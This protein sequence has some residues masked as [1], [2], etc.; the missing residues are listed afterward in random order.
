MVAGSWRGKVYGFFESIPTHGLAA[1]AQ[2]DGAVDVCANA[3]RFKGRVIGLTDDVAALPEQQ[4]GD[5]SGGQGR[6]IGAGDGRAAAN[7]ALMR[8]PSGS[9]S[10]TMVSAAG[11]VWPAT[12]RS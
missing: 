4:G 11:R 2:G 5:A 10:G 3:L 9:N 12:T 1:A 8:V 7:Q 6:Q